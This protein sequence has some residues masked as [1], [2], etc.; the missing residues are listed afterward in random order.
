[1]PANGTYETGARKLVL[2][3]LVNLAL[4]IWRLE[5]DRGC[6]AIEEAW[7]IAHEEQT[8]SFQHPT[9]QLGIQFPEIGL[10]PSM[11]QMPN[12]IPACTRTRF[13]QRPASYLSLAHA[14]K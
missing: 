7:E 4:S 13:L 6:G 14:R 3:Q 11:S 1:M 8:P 10:H 5:I 2:S 9:F 12:P